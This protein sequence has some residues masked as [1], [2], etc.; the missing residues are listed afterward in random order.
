MIKTTSKTCEESNLMGICKPGTHEPYPCGKPAT[1]IMESKGDGREYAMCAPCASHNLTRGM[2]E[3][4]TIEQPQEEKKS[5]ALA[6]IDI[7][8]PLQVYS[9]PNGLD[10]IIDKI[11]AEA[12]SIDRDISTEA[13][14]DNIRSLAFKLAKSKTFLDKMGK[15]LTEEQRA[16]ITAVNAERKRAWERMEALQ[17]EIRRPLTEWEERDQ[18]RLEAHEAALALVVAARNDPFAGT[19]SALIKERMDNL[20]ALM[21]REWEEFASKAIQEVAATRLHLDTMYKLSLKQEKDAADLARLRAEEEDR[22]RIFHAMYQEAHDE[23]VAFTAAYN[24]RRAAEEK[25]AREAEAERERVQREKEEAA[26]AAETERRRI[27]Q[28]RIDAEERTRKAQEKAREEKAAMDK[29]LAD[30]LQAAEDAKAEALRKADAEKAAAIEKERQRV[31]DEKA[32]EEKATAERERNKAHQGKINREILAAINTMID[33][34]PDEK[35]NVLQEVLKSIIGSIAKGE[36]P[37]VK[38]SY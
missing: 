6:L 18:R 13:G 27:E 7:K 11:E 16:Q 29:V 20:P 14:R 15:D 21:D 4:G 8:N 31:A 2:T 30:A 25:A 32:R 38:I 12:K 1:K 22:T 35:A 36:I 34:L 23:N 26:A 37:H 33:A 28:Q 17:E 24:A 10:S 9:T 3:V 19:D 5:S